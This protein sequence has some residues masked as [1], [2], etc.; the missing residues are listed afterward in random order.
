M[1]G[2]HYDTAYME[3]SYEK[4]RGGTGARLAAAGADDNASATAALLQAAPV[5]MNLARQGRLERDVWLL[6]L[7]GEEFPAD[8]LGARSFCQGLVEKTLKLRTAR[9]N[10]SICR[11]CASSA[12]S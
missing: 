10:L 8:C 5:F 1:L 9:T 3:D 6:H 4:T 7:T 2:D 12:F 11:R